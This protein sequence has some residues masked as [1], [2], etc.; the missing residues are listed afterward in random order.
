MSKKGEN[1]LKSGRGFYDYQTGPVKPVIPPELA[2]SFS[3]VELLAPTINF[4]A[5][6]VADGIGT[7]EAFNKA[8]KYAYGWPKGIFEYLDD[9]SPDAVVKT[10]EQKRE[11]APSW[12]KDFYQPSESVLSLQ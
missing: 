5:V 11:K 4:S 7:K 9:Y 10:L 1:G 8:F 3:P 2:D 6:C 12:L